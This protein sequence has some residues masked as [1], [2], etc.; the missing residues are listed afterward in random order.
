MPYSLEEMKAMESIG[1]G[2]IY[3]YYA[4]STYA[5]TPEP[6]WVPTHLVSRFFD[7]EPRCS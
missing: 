3:W 5:S 2:R 6:I 4:D 7:G 1:K